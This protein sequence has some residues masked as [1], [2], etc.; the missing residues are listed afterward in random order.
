MN[1]E[2]IIKKEVLQEQGYHLKKYPHTIKLDQNENPYGFPD[3]LKEQVLSRMK[4]LDW[5]RYPDFQMERLTELMAHFVGLPTNQVVVGS[6][7]NALIQSLF[8][9]VLSPGDRLI[10]TEPTF[11]LYRLFGQMLGAEPRICPLHEKDFSLAL[12]CLEAEL[13]H[14][15]AKLLV[16]CSPNNPTGNAFPLQQIRDLAAQFKGLVVIDEA[17]VEFSRQDAKILLQEFENIAILR[18]FSKAMAMAGLR[19]GYFMAHPE[20]CAQVQK[21]RLPYSV[22][23]MA[24]AAV[25]VCLSNR[26]AFEKRVGEIIA[27]REHIYHAVRNLSFVQIFPSDANFFLMRVPDSEALFHFFL[28][29]GILVRDVSKYPMLQNCLRFCIGKPDEMQ[30]FLTALKLWD[31]KHEKTGGN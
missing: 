7:S 6:G 24:E 18:T 11:T 1:W 19:F 4:R 28:E 29:Q 5:A 20:L 16:L 15:R 12:D 26:P 13:Q 30:H 3:E 22:N 8:W 17:Y 10:L 21:A 31:E 25:E 14:P 9:V 2:Y 23:I 27:Q